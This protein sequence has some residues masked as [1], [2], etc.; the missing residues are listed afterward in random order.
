MSSKLVLTS[1]VL[2]LFLIGCSKNNTVISKQNNSKSI[3][4]TVQSSEP[5]W[6]LDPSIDGYIGAIGSTKV[7]TN[8]TKQEKI[9]TLKAKSNLAKSIKVRVQSKTVL[10]KNSDGKSK[11]KKSIKLST[12][13]MLKKAIK[14]DFFIKDGYYYVWMVVKDD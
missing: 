10:A 2:G 1:L 3:E 8:K 11:Y 4:K 12:K 5:D 7:I 14:K 6:L 13:Q 9:A